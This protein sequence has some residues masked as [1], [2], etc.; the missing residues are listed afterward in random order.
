MMIRRMDWRMGKTERREMDAV[1]LA[2]IIES[3]NRS[4]LHDP[5]EGYETE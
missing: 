3:N 2:D 1:V 4:N 5:R